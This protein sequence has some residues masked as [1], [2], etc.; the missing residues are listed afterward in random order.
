MIITKGSKAAQTSYRNT[1]LH[2]VYPMYT[3]LNKYTVVKSDKAKTN[4]RLVLE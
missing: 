3:L 4:Q 1:S 2:T